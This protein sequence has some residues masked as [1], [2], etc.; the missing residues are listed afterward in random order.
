MSQAPTPLLSLRQWRVSFGGHEVVHGIDLDLAVGER[1]ALVGESGSGKTVTALGVLRLLGAAQLT[2]QC[3]FDG[4]DLMKATEARMQQLRGQDMAMV[5]QEPMTALNP[6]FTIGDQLAEV[7]LL[8]MASSRRDAW[9]RSAEML[10]QTGLNPPERFLRAYPHQLS[11][12]QRQRAM[13]AMALACRPKLLLAD[14]PTTALDVSMRGQILDLLDTLQRET[15]TAVLMITHDLNLVQRFA[16]RVA[17]ME[18]GH[19]VEQGPVN[20]VLGQPQHPYTRKLVD[21]KPQRQLA[22]VQAHAPLVAEVKDLRVSYR[23]RLPGWR[24]WFKPGAFVAVDQVNFFIR[25]GETLGVLGESGS[26]KSTLALALLGLLPFQGQLQVM[27]QGWRHHHQADLPLRRVVQVVFQDPFSSLSP[28]MTVED[29]VGEGLWV[30]QP[31]LSA[32]ARQALVNQVLAEVGMRESEFPG[33]LQRYPHEFSGG[34]RQR[35]A[36][37]RALV[38][39]PQLLVLDEPTSALDVSIQKQLLQL[40]QALQAER[41]LSFLLITHDMNVIQAMAHQVMVMKDGQ[42]VEAGETQVVLAQ[43]RHAYTQTL[44]QA[45]TPAVAR[46]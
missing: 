18:Q 44:V 41:G 7:L 29:V 15:G 22:P 13:I 21:S 36:V 28:R 27:G 19:V 23:T 5:F 20:Q 12:G 6:L 46:S 17:V 30:H 38:L 26:G 9:Q 45:S 33:L 24:G 34:Q 1:L 35:I 43:P 32:Q 11:G 2:G 37:A 40:L 8:K 3:W 25:Q 39:Q 42:V 14:E 31:G 10:S 16:D 4:E